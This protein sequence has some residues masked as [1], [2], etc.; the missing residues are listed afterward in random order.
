MASLAELMF[1]NASKT[2]SESTPDFT[3]AMKTG[4]QV[5][6]IQSNMELQQQEL[7]QK[8]ELLQYNKL[9]NLMKNINDGVTKVPKKAQRAFFQNFIKPQAEQMKIN[10]DDSFY[11]ALTSQD[12]NSAAVSES[13]SS[14]LGGV[15]V[16]PQTGQ[17]VLS[18]EARQAM[19]TILEAFGG[20]V[21][22]LGN[23]TTKVVGQQTAA[24][25][26]RNALIAQEQR[27][28]A[29]LQAQE[30]RQKTQIA[31]AG[32]VKLAQ[33]IAKE[34][35]VF[36]AGG[37]AA[38]IDAA[39][40]GYQEAIDA[41]KSGE[42]KLGTLAKQV[43]WGGDE[44]VL[45]RID[46]KAKA[47]IDK[48]RSNISI[49]ARTGDPNPTE[50]QINRI[51]SQEIDPRLS[52]AENIKKLESSI[53]RMQTDKLNKIK[54]FKDAGFDMGEVK[55]KQKVDAAFWQGLNPQQKEAVAKKFNLTVDQLNKRF[56][57]Q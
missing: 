47:L 15:T 6:Q 42:V 46:P 4:A 37:G 34:Y 35:S 3:E 24:A 27:Q 30:Q 41:L 51:L 5:A 9:S 40:K 45:A 53:K 48:I 21:D 50:K 22:L 38:S 28:Q 14:F 54:T 25:A 32:Q 20:R 44:D 31:S 11:D 16:D 33:D 19:P 2:I 57:V 52:N 43:P 56:G 29:T 12:M 13:I 39:I 26:Q 1:Q 10:I 36:R 7:E 17:A 8:K 18:D 55:P 49:K 23:F